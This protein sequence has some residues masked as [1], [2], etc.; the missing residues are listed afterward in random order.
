MM[1]NEE[2]IGLPSSEVLYDKIINVE[3]IRTVPNDQ[4]FVVIGTAGEV[5]DTKKMS[6]SI[7]I[8]E[9][10]Y[11]SYGVETPNQCIAIYKGKS[12]REYYKDNG[13]IHS[14]NVVPAGGTLPVIDS[15][16]W[17]TS[18]SFINAV[19]QSVGDKGCFIIVTGNGKNDYYHAMYLKEDVINTRDYIVADSLKIECT[20]GDIK[21]SISFNTNLIQGA[22]CYKMT[23]K[24]SNM[25]LD[26]DIR[27]ITRV[28][29]TAGY[30]LQKFLYSF[31]CPVFS[32]Y[33][34]SP[35][36]DG[37][38]V[39]ECLAVGNTG[40]FI[41]NTPVEL[42]YL[43]GT[44]TV[45]EFLY[46]IARGLK[47]TLKNYLMD[48]YQQLPLSM[49]KM[50]TFAEN[51]TAVIQWARELVQHRIALHEGAPEQHVDAYE[52][53]QP[54]IMMQVTNDALCVFALNRQ[55]KDTANNTATIISLDA[56]KGASF[57]G[58]A[59]TAK[60]VW[61]PRMTPG[62]VFQMQPNIINGANLP[63]TIKKE[64]YGASPEGQYL[65]RCITMSIS[66]STNG[67]ENEMSILAVPIKYI[68]SS[69][70]FT[71]EVTKTI[72][73]FAQEL[74]QQ[75]KTDGGFVIEFGKSDGK[76]V[77]A[78][79]EFK[80]QK[81]VTTNTNNMFDLDILKVFSSVKTYEIKPGDNLSTV[82]EKWFA[83]EKAPDGQKYCPFPLDLEDKDIDKLP[84]GSYRN[85]IPKA[86]LWP[87][88]AVLTYRYWR[89][90]DAT[91]SSRNPY[92]SMEH[93]AN[94]NLIRAGKQLVIPRIRDMDELARCR[95]VFKYAHMAYDSGFPSYGNWSRDWKSLYEY[96]GGTWK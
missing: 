73:Q 47:L 49:R 28:E 19:Q 4:I 30:R 90:Q 70:A 95:E 68:S 37:V 65:Y 7:S 16:K 79:E 18:E 56:V 45:N 72:D 63:N 52:Y 92:E 23:L 43:G 64:V 34:E 81:V 66:F 39:F 11:H 96:L 21:P 53:S 89:V 44:I 85:E 9:K 38:T 67:S 82:A 94:P 31:S 17:W 86:S 55:N 42:N 74:Y 10:G 54:Y 13:R 20:P 57:N 76:E 32:S 87:I 62:E 88:I 33:I 24:I 41:K 50:G 36:P 46:A 12:H 48:E 22:H 78:T 2:I 8:G 69:D 91:K 6:H 83:T 35:N 14:R 58:V 59:L 3:L 93:M 1:N 40:A 80:K 5:V 27:E 29:I 26:F 60:A 84:P 75:Y 15:E 71:S 25:N 61:N 51:G 77:A